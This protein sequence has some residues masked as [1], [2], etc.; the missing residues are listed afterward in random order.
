MHLVAARVVIPAVVPGVAPDVD[1][2]DA[3]G[4]AP[5]EP[6][7][8]E[9]AAPGVG[10]VRQV[11]PPEL[12]NTGIPPVGSTTSEPGLRETVVGMQPTEMRV[13]NGMSRRMS[14]SGD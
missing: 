5:P 13:A 9:V 3:P 8:T 6:V 14:V 2:G 11:T 1:P 12:C 7:T 10:M 4:V